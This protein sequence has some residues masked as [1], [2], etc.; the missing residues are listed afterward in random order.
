MLDR[1]FLLAHT[2]F[3]GNERPS[4]L[5]RNLLVDPVRLFIKNEPHKKTKL[6]QGRLRLISSVSLVDQIV[7]RLCSRDQNRAEIGLYATIPSK[8]GMG[9]HDQGLQ[10]LF[11]NVKSFS[12]DVAE[13]DISAWDWSVPAWLLELDARVR[14]DLYQLSE[15]DWRRRVIINRNFCLC[16]TVFCLSDGNMYEQVFPGIQLS[17]SYNTSS[18]NSRMRCI[19]A[20]I[21]GVSEIIAMGDDS[22]E[23]FDAKVPLQYEAL[24]FKLKMYRKVGKEEFEFC[25]M[26]FNGSWKASPVNTGKMFYNLIHAPSDQIERHIMYAQWRYE[27][28]HSPEFD[29]L[30]EL[31]RSTSFLDC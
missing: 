6:N 4:D 8:P 5:V 19:L 1:V 12:G 7:E 24:G 22:V 16:R 23:A 9:L 17:G 31:L 11:E 13:A 18:T 25:S 20:T 29:E 30:D 14:C 21:C 26:K 3:K 2:V 28:R 27:M 15:S 10:V